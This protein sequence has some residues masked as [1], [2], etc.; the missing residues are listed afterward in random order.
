MSQS[1]K[2]IRLLSRIRHSYYM[3][4]SKLYNVVSGARGLL[5]VFIL[6][7]PIWN[8]SDSFPE[9]C[10]LFALLWIQDCC[11]DIALFTKESAEKK[12]KKNVLHGQVTTCRLVPSRSWEG[13]DKSV[14]YQGKS[15][16][17]ARTKGRSPFQRPSQHILQSS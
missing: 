1:Y 8:K 7:I 14:L 9:I 16:L 5:V 4:F 13:F 10:S 6:G 3:L 12:S 15:K 17:F 11:K 2:I